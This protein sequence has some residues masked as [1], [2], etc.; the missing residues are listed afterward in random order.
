MTLAMYLVDLFT[1]GAN[2]GLPAIPL[3]AGFSEAGLPI[4][5]QSSSAL[6]LLPI[7]AGSAFQKATDHYK[8]CPK[9]SSFDL[10]KN[11]SKHND[12]I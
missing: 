3:P 5:I 6:Q 7:F 2:P 1:V 9:L 11:S 4:G 12:S 8:Q 10:T